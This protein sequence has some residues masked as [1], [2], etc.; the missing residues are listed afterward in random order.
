MDGG[1]AMAKNKIETL[2]EK[3]VSEIIQG[4]ELELIDVEFVKEQNWYLRVFIDKEAGLELEDCQFV[5]EKLE[6]Q[7]DELDPIKESYFLEVSSPGLDRPLKRTEDY[8]RHLGD[9][10][11]VHTYAPIDGNKMFI[12]KLL[13]FQ[14]NT[15]SIETDKQTLSLPSHQ[16]SQIRLHID[17]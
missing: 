11:E 1:A 9:M 16:V 2:V 14:D 7:L 5:S 15:I 12:G 3:I 6:Q 4:S 13:G 17:F 10:V 8:Q